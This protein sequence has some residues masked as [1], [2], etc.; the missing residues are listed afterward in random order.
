MATTIQFGQEARVRAKQQLEP[1]LKEFLDFVVIP[2]LV[3]KYLLEMKNENRLAIIPINVTQS[4][5]KHPASA[6][7]VL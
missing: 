4:E 1:R 6:E 7:G 3:K 2:A 5:S